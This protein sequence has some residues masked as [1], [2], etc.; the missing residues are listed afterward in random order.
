MRHTCASRTVV[1]K[2]EKTKERKKDDVFNF[3]RFDY[4]SILVVLMFAVTTL[5][6][7]WIAVF[8]FASHVSF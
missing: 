8:A 4:T 3:D 7:E 1:K 2:A 5:V 6:R